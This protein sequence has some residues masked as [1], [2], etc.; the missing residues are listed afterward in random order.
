ALKQELRRLLKYQGDLNQMVVNNGMVKT[1]EEALQE[2]PVV[3]GDLC[4]RDFWFCANE[5]FLEREVIDFSNQ[6]QEDNAAEDYTQVLKVLHYHSLDEA[7]VE[8]GRA[9]VECWEDMEFGEAIPGLYAQL[10]NNDFLLITTVH[11]QGKSIGYTAVTL[12]T[13]SFWFVGYSAFLAS[14]RHL[15]ELQRSQKQ[16][17][18]M[19]M[20]D[21]L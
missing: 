19:Y 4:Y 5:G 14:F 9:E 16:L 2:V 21:C 7:S 18:K 11:L 10:E 6:R 13:E 3:M 20:E 1:L 17:M 8:F 15:M 12:D